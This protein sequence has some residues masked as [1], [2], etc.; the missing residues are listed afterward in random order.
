M[1]NESRK[2]VGIISINI[3][4]YTPDDVGTMLNEEFDIAVRTGYH[5]APFIH[6]FID[7]RKYNGTVRISLG[8]FNTKEDI[9]KLV[10][11]LKTF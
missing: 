6:D 8:Y 11:A 1:A 5:C 3:E 4:G 7:S 10:K 2:G 9:D